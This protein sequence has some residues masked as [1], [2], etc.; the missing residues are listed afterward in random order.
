MSKL[1]DGLSGLFGRWRRREEK[2][3]ERK[4]ESAPARVSRPRYGADAVTRGAFGRCRGPFDG[5]RA[6]RS[7]EMRERYGKTVLHG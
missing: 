3:E 1:L 6:L 7:A 5:G 4:E 2:M